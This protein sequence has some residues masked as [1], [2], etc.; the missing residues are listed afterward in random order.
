VHA[1]ISVGRCS[2]CRPFVE[3]V[4]Q[5]DP[6]NSLSHVASEILEFYDGRFELAL[7]AGRTAYELDRV[8]IFS[9]GWYVFPLVVNS[10]F[11]EAQDLLELW[12]RD[13][14]GHPWLLGSI[15]FLRSVQRKKAESLSAINE[16]V[17]AVYRND[18]AGIW[19]LADIYTLNGETD[20]ALSWLEHGLDIGCFNY[21]YLSRLDPYLE[22]LRGDPRFQSLMVRVK[23]VWETFEV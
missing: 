10:R 23:R 14:P 19:S 18:T 4:L 3:R 21:P 7:E 11:D 15:S 12:Q 20:E 17:L 2:A 13:M 9:R 8:G 6:L 22:N 16:S 1:G 5:T